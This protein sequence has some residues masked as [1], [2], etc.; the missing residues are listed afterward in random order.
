MSPD[1]P[2]NIFDVINIEQKTVIT[3]HDYS[4]VRN[5]PSEIG[6]IS[7]Q[8]EDQQR[9]IDI[10]GSEIQRLISE[11]AKLSTA[12]P[13][14]WLQ[15][16]EKSRMS[17]T[18][19]SEMSSGSGRAEKVVNKL[20]TEYPNLHWFRGGELRIENG[21]PTLDDSLEMADG[22]LGDMRAL[23]YARSNHDKTKR[24]NPVL[25]VVALRDIV[26][27]VKEGALKAG[28]HHS[29]DVSLGVRDRNK[30]DEW[31]DTSL[32]IYSVP[33]NEEELNELKQI[34]GSKAIK[35]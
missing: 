18:I 25:Y 24:A 23:S 2:E 8:G 28:S 7:P 11:D 1:S 9:G 10:L 35:I 33:D 15:S 31:K 5:L 6:F 17:G 32:K 13:E 19:L 4:E 16:Q 30:F 12:V 27:G 21:V 20:L 3:V 14:D 26:R 29:Y 34:L 22:Y